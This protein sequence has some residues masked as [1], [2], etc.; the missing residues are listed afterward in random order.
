MEPD[1]CGYNWATLS[2]AGHKYRDVVHQV[3][4]VDAR[5]TTL[6]RKKIIVANSKEVKPG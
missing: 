6:L 3:G 4:G 2:A 5:L 1:A